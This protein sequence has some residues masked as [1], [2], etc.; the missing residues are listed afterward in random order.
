MAIYVLLLFCILLTS[1]SKGNFVSALYLMQK[2]KENMKY[3]NVFQ[4][5]SVTFLLLRYVA[6]IINYTFVAK[7]N[8]VFFIKSVSGY[9]PGFA[10]PAQM[11]RHAQMITK[12]ITR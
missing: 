5:I 6:C 10:Q 9:E 12:V 11:R 3:T 8:N 2:Y 4:L 7:L 1:L